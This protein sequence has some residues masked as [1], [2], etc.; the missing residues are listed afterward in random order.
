M[1]ARATSIY[2]LRYFT[3]N[4]EVV[5][6]EMEIALKDLQVPRLDSHVRVEDGEAFAAVGFRAAGDEMARETAL[7]VIDWLEIR[8]DHARLFT[9]FGMHRREVAL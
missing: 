5:L 2:S 6:A 1:S 9:G 4:P 3:T 8:P 7:A